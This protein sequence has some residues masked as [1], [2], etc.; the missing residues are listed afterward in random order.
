[1]WSI[2]LFLSSSCSY[3]FAILITYLAFDAFHMLFQVLLSLTWVGFIC[4]FLHVQ[5]EKALREMRAQT[6][7]VKFTS[8][9]KLVEAH[10][11]EASLEERSLEVEQ[12][13]HAADAKLAEASRKSSEIERKLEE[14]EA[15]ERKIQRDYVSLDNE[16]GLC[17]IFNF[18]PT[19]FC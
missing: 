4:L 7:E 16:Y 19:Q 18:I 5:L 13:L 17:F 14:V 3:L 6:A 8:D 1:M 12:K 11:L 15:R 9:R 2:L 10:A